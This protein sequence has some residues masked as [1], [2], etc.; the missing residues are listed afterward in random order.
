MQIVVVGIIIAVQIAMFGRKSTTDELGDSKSATEN[1][2]DLLISNILVQD[3]YPY[4]CNCF[5]KI[6]DMIFI[7]FEGGCI[8]P[9]ACRSIMFLTDDGVSFFYRRDALI[10]YIST[11][12]AKPIKK[13]NPSHLVTE[14][15]HLILYDFHFS[16]N[17]EMSGILKN[18]IP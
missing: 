3:H 12:S 7:Y 4:H 18:A 10:E 5:S 9:K 2:H 17:F 1:I 14:V 13:L 16:I 11:N 8:P 15:K 6:R